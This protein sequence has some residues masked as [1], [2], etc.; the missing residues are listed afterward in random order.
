MAISKD[1]E[2]QHWKILEEMDWRDAHW[3]TVSGSPG[4]NRSNETGR[5]R[6]VSCQKISL[7][8]DVL[9]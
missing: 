8:L 9:A 3:K 7:K 4:N 1:A 6:D 5:R 2:N